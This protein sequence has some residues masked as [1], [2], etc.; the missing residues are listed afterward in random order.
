MHEKCVSII[1]QLFP[2]LLRKHPD[3]AFVHK[4]LGLAHNAADQ[5]SN[6]EEEFK[7]AIAA[8]PD[9]GLSL[10]A[11]RAPGPSDCAFQGRDTN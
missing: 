11:Q 1:T 3:S 10:L 7:K 8:S 6:A 5:P 9:S 4:P 2:K